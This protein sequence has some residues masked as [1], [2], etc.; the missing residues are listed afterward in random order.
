MS[1]FL[2]RMTALSKTPADFY[3]QLVQRPKPTV[4]AEP[5]T[6]VV[7][8]PSDTLKFPPATVVTEPV[9]TVVVKPSTT[10]VG[11]FWRAESNNALF[12]ASWVRRIELAQ[13]ALTHA[14]EKV[15][16]CLWG[17]KN[18]TRDEFRL[19]RLGYDRIAKVARLT[20]RNVALIIERLIDKGFVQ[21]EQPADTLH[22]IPTQYRVLSYRAVKE[23]LARRQRHWIVRSGN[24]VLYVHPLTLLTEPATTVVAGLATTVVTG[25]STTVAGATTVT[26]VAGAPTTVVAATTL[27]DSKK[28]D[29][30]QAS[31]TAPAEVTR[32]AQVIARQVGVDA[33]TPPELLR[34]CRNADPGASA[35]EIIYFT[36]ITLRKGLQTRTV[37][38]WEGFLLDR[39]PRYFSPGGAELALYRQQSP[40]PSP[41][42]LT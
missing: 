13:D 11:E 34:R 5:T 26:V 12:P 30:N 10:V 7:T 33:D 32:L 17:P 22:R 36:A 37:R 20:K 18:L 27:L 28:L 41:D 21:L 8:E 24:G 38:T 35:E 9:T 42:D 15:Y 31:S 14:E 16:D 25:L 29:R 40:A 23:E 39:V 1:K 4:V 6:T 19:V 2:R 3:P